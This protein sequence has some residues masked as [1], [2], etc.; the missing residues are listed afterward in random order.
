MPR[1][2]EDRDGRLHLKL[3][4]GLIKHLLKDEVVQF[5]AIHEVFTASS[6][7]FVPDYCPDGTRLK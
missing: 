4:K 2:V 6:T 5:E 3:G 7:P 1:S